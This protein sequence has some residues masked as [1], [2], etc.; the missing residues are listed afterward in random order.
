MDN[1]PYSC[2]RLSPTQIR[3][4]VRKRWLQIAAFPGNRIG[5]VFP[6]LSPLF[7]QAVAAPTEVAP[8]RVPCEREYLF[9]PGD[10]QPATA[11]SRGRWISTLSG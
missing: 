1:Y 10:C 4:I 2:W 3:P 7:L 5:E 6:R 9:G 8:Y 11:L